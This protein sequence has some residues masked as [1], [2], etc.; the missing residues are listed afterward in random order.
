MLCTILFLFPAQQLLSQTPYFHWSVSYGG[1]DDDYPGEVLVLDDG[2][3]ISGST[4]SYGNQNDK[5]DFY[6]IRTDEVGNIIWQKTYGGSQNEQAFSLNQTQ[7]GGYIMAG[8]TQSWGQGGS[9]GYMVRVDKD[10]DTLWTKYMGGLTW[11]QFYDGIP[12]RDQGFVFTG[13]SSVYLKGDQVYVVKTDANGDTLWTQT[14][15]GD[16]QDYGYCILE[17]ITSGYAALGH[18][19]SYPGYESMGYMVRLNDNGNVT[20]YSGFGDTGEDYARWF[21]Q[22]LDHSFNIVG[23]TQSFGNGMDDF[24]LLFTNEDGTPTS[25]FTYGGSGADICYNGCRDVDGGVLMAGHTWSFGL[26]APNMFMVKAA[27]NGDS[28]WALD[29]GDDD[30]EYAWDIKPTLDGGYVVLGREY[31]ITT[32]DNNIVLLKYGPNPSFVYTVQE[33]NGLALPIQDEQTTTDLMTITAAPNSFVSGIS[34]LVDTI[35]HGEI[36]DLVITLAHEGIL[37]TLLMNPEG[38]GMNMLQTRFNPA[39]SCDAQ[40]GTSPMS[41]VYRPYRPTTLF[42]GTAV[43]GDW[44]LQIYD[45]QAGNTGTLESWELQIYYESMVGLEEPGNAVGNFEYRIYP[46]PFNDRLSVTSDTHAEYRI[47]DILGRKINSGSL[48]RGQNHIKTTDY[49]TG[50]YIIEITKGQFRHV[51]K[52]IKE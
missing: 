42:N 48:T 52:V 8:V 30:W 16:H 29:W 34:V 45:S 6:L 49:P 1:N 36:K 21:D 23:S 41:G 7:D 40:A 2:Y 51:Q 13:F 37:D 15:G 3:L 27:A 24:W 22:N 47:L 39:A 11:D 26:D 50:I 19:W 31:S 10:G 18:S 9:D 43:N 46:N 32:G 4:K 25:W 14:Q 38:G 28:L 17:D 35:M 12:T 44:E 33:R 20:W 5:Y